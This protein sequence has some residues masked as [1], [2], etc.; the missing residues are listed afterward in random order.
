MDLED[1]YNLIN[2]ENLNLLNLTLP[3]YLLYTKKN[4]K[5][6]NLIKLKPYQNIFLLDDLNPKLLYNFDF[7]N[8][9]KNEKNV[10][11]FSGSTDAN[12]IENFEFIDLTLISNNLED[13]KKISLKNIIKKLEY[14]NINYFNLIIINQISYQYY[15]TIL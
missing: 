8:Y 7:S 14:N 2:K 13:I 10:K 12:I 11:I 6:K 1:N 4:N 5:Y 3:K 15:I 9:I